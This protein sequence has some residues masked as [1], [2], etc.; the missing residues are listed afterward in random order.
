M[1]PFKY[2]EGNSSDSAIAKFSANSEYL[3]GG[4]TLIDLMKLHVMTP[5]QLIDVTELPKTNNEMAH[6]PLIK[7]NFPFVSEAI[8]TGASVQLRNLATTSGNILQR[9]R[10]TYFRDPHSRCN[11]R[12]PGSGCDAIDGYNRMHAI[13]GVSEQ[14][15]ASHPS[16][17]CVALM[18]VGASVATQTANATR[19]IPFENFYTLPGSTPHIENVLAPGE[20]I[21][22][23]NLPKRAWYKHSTY[24]KI[25]DRSSYAFALTSAAVS[26]EFDGQKIKNARIAMGGIGA[27]PW[28]AYA[29]EDFLIGKT[30]TSDNFKT[31]A[32]LLTQAAK[33]KKFNEFKVTLAEQTLIRALNEVKEKS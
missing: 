24:V 7:K 13:L 26:L 14:C 4:T 17:L 20:L 1:Q 29:V 30:L 32:K 21:V 9:T 10:C 19:E 33:P 27:I 5:S 22:S 23:V 28:R 2:S 16:D 3:A 31:A 25:R 6:H 18:A 8:L 12:N 11:K 15:I